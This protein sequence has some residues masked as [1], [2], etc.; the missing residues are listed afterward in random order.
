MDQKKQTLTASNIRY[1][2][3]LRTLD[4]ETGIRC[5]DIAQALGFSKPSVHEMMK[6]LRK[7]GLV[8]MAKCGTVFLTEDGRALAERHIVYFDAVRDYL[9]RELALPPEDSIHAACALITEVS[10]ES[11]ESMY[12]QISI[13]S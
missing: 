6:T 5:T 7:K 8:E 10:D 4:C 1:L 3:T 11:I 2:I 13:I 9:Q 12:K